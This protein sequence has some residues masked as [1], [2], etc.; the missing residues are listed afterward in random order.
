MEKTEYFVMT[1]YTGYSYTVKVVDSIEESVKLE[2][3]GYECDCGF[4]DKKQANKHAKELKE[5][6]G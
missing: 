2:K 5:F 1:K 3:R 6:L 4:S